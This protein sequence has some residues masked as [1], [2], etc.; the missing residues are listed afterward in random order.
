MLPKVLYL[1]L[2]YAHRQALEFLREGRRASRET[3]KE[4]GQRKNGMRKITE[5][6]QGWSHSWQVAC[7]CSAVAKCQKPSG[8]ELLLQ[9]A[10]QG[11]L[12]GSQVGERLGSR[13]PTRC[14]PRCWEGPGWCHTLPVTVCREDLE[15]SRAHWS[16]R[17]PQAH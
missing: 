17:S 6:K 11:G 2:G 9:A 12:Q 1:L 5:E 7:L 14:E 13:P 16:E 10:E 3:E 8:G 4:R 15:S